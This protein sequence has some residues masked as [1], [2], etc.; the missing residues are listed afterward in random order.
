MVS[1]EQEEEFEALESIYPE[2]ERHEGELMSFTIMLESETDENQLQV[3]LRLQLPEEYPNAVLECDVLDFE[4][5][6]PED[7]VGIEKFI[8][9]TC[10]DELGEQI[11]FTVISGVQ[12]YLNDLVDTMEKRK[13]EE[14]QRKKA[15]EEAA[16]RKKFE[17]TRVTVES[18]LV[19]KENFD[20]ELE[21]LKTAA[22]KKAEAE[23]KGRMTG[24]QLFLT[25]IAGGDEEVKL[26]IANQ[27][28]V[29]ESLF[30]DL[31]DLDLDEELDIPDE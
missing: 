31:G 9:E 4:N 7:C 21:S 3:E 8:R 16:A 2:I 12:D 29:D 6:D 18:F 19:W 25:K 20:A 17:G 24:K 28:H 13:I 23:M 1:E 14:A 10:Q 15:E 30:D 11:C 22:Q 5:L 27:V 26:A